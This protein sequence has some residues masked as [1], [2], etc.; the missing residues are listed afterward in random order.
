MLENRKHP[1]YKTKALARIADILEG[2]NLVKD[3]SITGCCVESPAFAEIMPSMIYQLEIIPE[4]N[5]KINNFVMEVEVKWL[6]SSGKGS[7]IG[8]GIL[9]S[10]KGEEFQRYVDYLA[11]RS[12]LDDY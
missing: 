10:P 7:A 5:S 11:Y 6:R 4:K 3:I 9:S 12:S 8:F 1:R 2:E